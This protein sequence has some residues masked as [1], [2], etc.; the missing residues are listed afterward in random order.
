MLRYWLTILL[1]S[2][3]ISCQSDPFKR[4]N[5]PQCIHNEDNS[6]E[7]S[8]RGTSFHETNLENYVCTPSQSFGRY[9]VYVI[10]IEDKLIKCEREVERLKLYQD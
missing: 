1:V 9:Q 10:D 8:H 7:C 4:P 5:E 2:I 3:T 6:A